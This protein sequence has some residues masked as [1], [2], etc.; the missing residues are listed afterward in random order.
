MKN[1]R[2]TG[3]AISAWMLISFAG[4]AN[5]NFKNRYKSDPYRFSTLGQSTAGNL[6]S[7]AGCEDPNI[8]PVQN[9]SIGG[10]NEFTACS[11]LQNPFAIDLRG[12]TNYSTTQEVCV[13]PVNVQTGVGIQLYPAAAGSGHLYL[14]QCGTTDPEIEAHLTFSNINYNALLVVG[15]GNVGQMEAFLYAGASSFAPPFSSGR[16]R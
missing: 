2:F 8:L 13:F 12:R 11:D 6:N 16:F 9:A 14:F 7:A 10:E 1:F 15:A 5:G 3:I 4:C